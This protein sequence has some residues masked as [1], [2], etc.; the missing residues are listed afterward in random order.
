MTSPESFIGLDI[1]GTN[2]KALAFDRKGNVLADET[3]PTS[4]DG[5]TRWRERARDLVQSVLARS[6]LPARIG[7]AAPGLAARDGLS[8]ACL[9]SR[10]PGL[11]GLNWQEWLSH[12]SP[13]PVFNDAQAALLGECWRGAAQNTDNVALLTLGTGI[14]GA[15]MVDGRL[16]HGHLGRA[17]HL[18][19][20][21]LNPDGAHDIV[22]TPGSLEDAIGEC[23]L[24]QRSSG[25]FS[26][27]RELVAAFHAGS[28]DAAKIWLRSVRALAAALAGLINVLDPE[29]F[30]LGGGIADAGDAL[31]KPLQSALDE[32]E[33]RPNAARVRV[34]KAAL[35][36]S[37]GA[38][39]AAFGVRQTASDCGRP[40]VNL[41][42][43][44]GI[45]S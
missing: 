18:G 39:G 27:T 2:L 11:E 1:G 41:P 4:D 43:S 9:P 6:P 19:H 45:L 38:T 23:T 10:L 34:V 3:A 17:G 37:A 31:F 20:I 15:A 22:N 25:K 29:I 44:T 24:A 5:S 16:L 33:W 7:V 35:G 8:I 13:I 21:S 36:R 30:I 40:Q 28:E 12:N 26:S 14:G 42:Q 32:F